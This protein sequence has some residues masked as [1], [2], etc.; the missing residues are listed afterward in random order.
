MGRMCVLALG[1]RL[2]QSQQPPY[3]WWQAA[4]VLADPTLHTEQ[5]GA[6]EKAQDGRIPSSELSGV[7]CDARRARGKLLLDLLRGWHPIAETPRTGEANGQRAVRSA[8]KEQL[9]C[10][11][12]LAV[13]HCRYSITGE[14][15]P[16]SRPLVALIITAPYRQIGRA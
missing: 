4:T 9:W 15:V 7:V 12:D 5:R 11:F 3:P 10:A 2:G 16:K 8:G 14:V 1:Y 13:L 6:G